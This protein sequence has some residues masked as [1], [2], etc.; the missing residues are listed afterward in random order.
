MRHR[1]VLVARNVSVRAS[2][3]HGVNGQLAQ[4]AGFTIAEIRVL[5]GE[6]L[7][8]CLKAYFD[9]QPRGQERMIKTIVLSNSG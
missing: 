8:E 9:R 7:G 4:D 3:D 2:G 5:I 6:T 1:A